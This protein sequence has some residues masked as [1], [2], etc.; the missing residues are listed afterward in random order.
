MARYDF[1]A[2]DSW[3]VILAAPSK[4]IHRR[5][6]AGAC[7]VFLMAIMA[8]ATPLTFQPTAIPA[9]GTVVFSDDFSRNWS[10]WDT[11][12]KDGSG[13]AYENG[14][15]RILVN[16]PQYDYW[17]MSSKKLIDSRI[18]A[19]ATLMGGPTD[20]NYGLVC[21]FN[22]NLSYYAFL[23]SS[24]GYYGVIRLIEGQSTVFGSG[25]MEYSTVILQGLVSNHIR[26]DCIGDRL[27]LYV[28]GIQ[29]A[30]YQDSI[31]K[32]GEAGVIAGTY[33]NPGTDIL[34]DN[35]FILQP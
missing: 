12:I 5:T 9:S 30:E 33:T 1:S 3:S 32:E 7:V 28:N 22:E 27:T 24:D 35:F 16:Q 13:I 23:I 8:C 18:E 20:N 17:S 21:R 25:H 4:P 29:L 14:G 2:K 11:W 34:F 31:L 15:L 10:G 19:D 26:A 6:L